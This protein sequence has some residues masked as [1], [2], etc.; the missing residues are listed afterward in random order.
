MVNEPWTTWIAT[1]KYVWNRHQCLNQCGLVRTCDWILY[2]CNL[3]RA[4]SVLEV[5]TKWVSSPTDPGK[6]LSFTIEPFILVL[7]M[8]FRDLEHDSMQCDRST[9]QLQ[10]Q[11]FYK[12]LNLARPNPTPSWCNQLH[13]QKCSNFGR[14]TLDPHWYKHPS[15]ISTFCSIR[16]PSTWHNLFLPTGHFQCIYLFVVADT[17]MYLSTL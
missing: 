17:H 8:R 6:A 12:L 1:R 2:L 10:L 5:G 11:N 7:K 15:Q 16:V 9:R 4:T 14:T 13:I 3:A